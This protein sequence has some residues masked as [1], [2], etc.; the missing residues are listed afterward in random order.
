MLVVG[1][2]FALY[3]RSSFFTHRQKPL[4]NHTLSVWFSLYK[5]ENSLKDKTFKESLAETARF[6]H[7]ATTRGTHPTFATVHRKVAIRHTPNRSFRIS[8]H[9]RINGNHA[10]RTVSVYLAETAR[11]EL[12]GDCSLTDFECDPLLLNS[13]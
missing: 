1:R 8:P 12:A 2:P 5:R 9:K 3:H 13:P 6:A 11:F 10:L 4:W 7:V